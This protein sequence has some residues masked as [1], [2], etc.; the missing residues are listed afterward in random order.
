MNTLLRVKEVVNVLGTET[1]TK[2]NV[3]ATRTNYVQ[4]QIVHFVCFFFDCDVLKLM[5]RPLALL[6]STFL[7]LD[8]MLKYNIV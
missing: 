2:W 5:Q 4:L 6:M 1:E 3:S 7:L 8:Q